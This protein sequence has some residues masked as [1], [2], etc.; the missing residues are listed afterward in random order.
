MKLLQ[1]RSLMCKKL[2][3]YLVQTGAWEWDMVCNVMKCMM[4]YPNATFIGKITMQYVRTIY[5]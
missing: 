2:T 3:F 1:Q 5:V 4:V